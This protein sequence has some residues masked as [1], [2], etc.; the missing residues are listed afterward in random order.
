MIYDAKI[1][2]RLWDNCYCQQSTELEVQER[3]SKNIDWETGKDGEFKKYLNFII[4]THGKHL[5]ITFQCNIPPK[6][7]CTHR[8][9][10]YYQQ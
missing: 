10:D 1:S 6:H 5:N 8:K 2:C 3:I 7:S 9:N 4:K